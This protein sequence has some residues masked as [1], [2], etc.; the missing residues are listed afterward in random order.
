MNQLFELDSFQS[1]PKYNLENIIP[2]NIKNFGVS[3]RKNK[4]YYVKFENGKKI[5]WGDIRYQQYND[6]LRK[7][8]NLNHHDEKRR[9]LY[10]SRASKIKDK[11]G[12]LTANDPNSPNFFSCRLL[13]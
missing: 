5:H 2:E 12:N 6:K 3:D 4:K 7:Y 8:K 1:N 11:K 13:W 10:L 9:D